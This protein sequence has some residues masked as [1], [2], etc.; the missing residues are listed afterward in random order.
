[1]F[2]WLVPLL[3]ADRSSLIFSLVIRRM[4]LPDTHSC[5]TEHNKCLQDLKYPAASS[6]T[7]KSQ[8]LGAGKSIAIPV[9]ARTDPEGSRRFRLPEFLGIQHM[10]VAAFIPQEIPLVLISV[11]G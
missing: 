11:I 3:S 4:S 2:S 7:K 6:H 10:K 9:Q 1:V 8:Y 5:Y